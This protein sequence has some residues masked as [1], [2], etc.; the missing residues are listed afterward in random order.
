MVRPISIPENP[1]EHISQKTI[2][3]PESLWCILERLKKAF[4]EPSRSALVRRII[5]E[6]LK[7]KGLI[8]NLG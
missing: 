3:L 4:H 1:K 8:R 6:W 2:S 7:E 5:V